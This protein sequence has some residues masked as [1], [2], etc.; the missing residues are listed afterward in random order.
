MPPGPWRPGTGCWPIRRARISPDGAIGEFKDGA[1][2]IAVANQVPIVP[3]A[4]Q[5]TRLIW[6]PGHRTIR[7]GHVRVLAGR[8]LPTSGLTQDDV[9]RLRDQARD[10]ICAAQ[11]DLVTSMSA[12]G[13]TS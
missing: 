9:A 1:F 12:K 7:G 11:R 3:A 2:V 5:G 13:G 4:I 6:P 8:P 10:A